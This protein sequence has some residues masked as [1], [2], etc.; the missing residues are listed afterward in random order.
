MCARTQLFCTYTAVHRIIL[1]A[2][3]FLWSFFTFF[4]FHKNKKEMFRFQQKCYFVAASASVWAGCWAGTCILTEKSVSGQ[5]FF[6]LAFFTFLLA[7]QLLS[8][9]ASITNDNYCLNGWHCRLPAMEPLRGFLL[10]FISF[11]GKE[12]QA[13]PA[14]D[15]FISSITTIIRQVCLF[16]VFFSRGTIYMLFAGFFATPQCLFC[17]FVGYPIET[18]L[19]LFC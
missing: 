10:L 7:T 2:Q 17:L 11:S 12:K 19:Y 5:V 9:F 8:S 16:G 4:F 15:H 6:F 3:V 1:N 18:K 14:V 13:V